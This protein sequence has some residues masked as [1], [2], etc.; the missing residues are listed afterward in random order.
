MQRRS[1]SHLPASRRTDVV[2]D[3][4]A[5]A[6]SPAAAL[7]PLAGAP[8]SSN[9]KFSED[10]FLIVLAGKSDRADSESWVTG[11]LRMGPAAWSR[12]E[13]K[14]YPDILKDFV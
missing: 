1:Q 6:R 3:T 8:A 11:L 4:L 7:A 2:P 5:G 14:L 9:E 12:V 10:Q 13:K